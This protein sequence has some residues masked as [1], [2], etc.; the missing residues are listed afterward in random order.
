MA[1]CLCDTFFDDVAIAT[2]QVLEHLGCKVV[3]PA[4]Q[5]CCG[6]PAFNA[7]DWPVARR[8]I[9]SMRK[10]FDERVPIVTPSGSCASMLLHGLALAFEGEP[11]CDDALRLT[12]QT[13]ELCDFIVHGLGVRTWPGQLDGKLAFHRSCHCRGTPSADAAVM[14][15]SSIEGVEVVE[16]AEPEQCC[17]FGGAFSVSFPTV[18]KEVGRVKLKHVAATEPD[19]LVSP[20][21]GCLLHLGGLM[22]RSQTPFK[23]MHVAQVL[24]NALGLSVDDGG[25]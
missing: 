21:M 8:V 20:D 4:D 14:L 17:G 12:H 22:D 5:T 16:P 19:A 9:R 18:S 7:G 13:W 10:A 3:F 25:Q 11:D 6:Q 24:R 15:L 23:R 2:V 1:T